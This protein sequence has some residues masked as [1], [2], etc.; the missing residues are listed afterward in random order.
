MLAG[1]TQVLWWELALLEGPTRWFWVEGFGAWVSVD[2]KTE[3]NIQA[4]NE[5]IM[6]I[7]SINQL[8][9]CDEVLMKTLNIGAQVSFLGWQCSVRVVRH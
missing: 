6:S 5:S 3:V 9:L 4:T 2:L 1:Y 8:C 7:E